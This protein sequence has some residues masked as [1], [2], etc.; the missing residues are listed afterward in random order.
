MIAVK[1]VKATRRPLSVSSVMTPAA[2]LVTVTPD[3]TLLEAADLFASRR[4]HGAPVLAGGRLVGVVSASA[5][6]EF[7]VK[8]PELREE[9]EEDP[10]ESQQ[11]PEQWEEGMNPPCRFFVD[12]WSEGAEVTRRFESARPARNVFAEYVVGDVMTRRVVSV[13][14][15]SS[16]RQAARV[17]MRAEVGRVL[18]CE[19]GRLEGLVST[20]DILR[21]VA[22][23][24]LTPPPAFSGR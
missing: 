10:W 20:T 18:V 17:M 15:T 11:Q 12:L 22:H 21:A 6:L 3:T 14:P 13:R 16:I 23:G 9:D 1:E 2:R 5:L 8:A 24:R 7:A 4:V 19:H